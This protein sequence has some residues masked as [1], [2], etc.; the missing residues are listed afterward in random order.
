MGA[1]LAAKW[2]KTPTE[3]RSTEHLWDAGGAAQTVR[4]GTLQVDLLKTSRK[5]AKEESFSFIGAKAGMLAAMNDCLLHATGI[6][7]AG[8]RDALN[9]Q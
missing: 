3:T 6:T 4:R 8:V 1:L 7:N 9:A 2:S 5:S